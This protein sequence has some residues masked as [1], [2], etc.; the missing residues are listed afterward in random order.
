MVSITTPTPIPRNGRG[1]D[2]KGRSSSLLRGGFWPSVTNSTTIPGSGRCGE[3]PRPLPQL[4]QQPT[5]PIKRTVPIP[6][7][8][9]E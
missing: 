2:V 4:S 7:R 8:L 9:Q 3:I 6:P 5:E 1:L